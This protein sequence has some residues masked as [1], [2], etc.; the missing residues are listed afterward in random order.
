[1]RGAGTAGI[2][3]AGNIDCASVK[4]FAD[5]EKLDFAPALGSPLVGAAVE[6][7]QGMSTED[8]FGR[9][10]NSRSAVGAVENSRG[11]GAKK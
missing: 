10:R 7:K 11:D 8:F 5:P 9:Q 6:V 3:A 2:H 4:C 1:M